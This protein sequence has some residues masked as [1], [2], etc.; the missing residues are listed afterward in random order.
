[1]FLLDG[2]GKEKTRQNETY[3]YRA[4]SSIPCTDVGQACFSSA[5]FAVFLL[6]LEAVALE[7]FSWTKLLC[8]NVVALQCS[9]IDGLE[10]REEDTTVR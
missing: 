8:N 10:C 9:T 5:S 7:G 3:H 2:S 4:S 1:M 6:W